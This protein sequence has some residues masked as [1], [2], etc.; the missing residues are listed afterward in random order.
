M[1]N[2]IGLRSVAVL[3]SFMSLPVRAEN[4]K[5]QQLNCEINL[6]LESGWTRLAP[7]ADIVKFSIRSPDHA[8]IISLTV[9]AVD[10]SVSEASFVE[11]FKKRWFEHGTGKG[12]S[13]EHIQVAGRPGYRLKDIANLGGKEVNRANIFVIEGGRLYQFDA[14]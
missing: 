13:E 3:V 4:W 14:M 10:Q 8:K 11:R 5:S 6:P 9:L 2:S 12:V 7:S 1:N